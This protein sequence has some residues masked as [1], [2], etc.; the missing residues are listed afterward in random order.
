MKL[1]VW[2]IIFWLMAKLGISKY[3]LG[4]NVNKYIN[5]RQPGWEVCLGIPREVKRW[6]KAR[7]ERYF[8][9]VWLQMKLRWFDISMPNF[10]F[11]GT[12]LFCSSSYHSLSKPSLYVI[13]NMAN[14][15]GTQWIF[16][17]LK[18]YQSWLH[19]VNFFPSIR[20]FYTETSW[21]CFSLSAM[22]HDL[23]SVI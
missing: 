22:T 19:K 14:T 6:K 12:F 16:N 7:E 8:L 20:S 21:P 15:V 4:L 9:E 10:L 1:L 3:F 2:T 18:R 17:L 23:T 11:L 5:R 13:S